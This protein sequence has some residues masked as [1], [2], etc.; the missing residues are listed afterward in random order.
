MKTWRELEVEQPY[1]VQ[2]LTNSVKRNRVSHAYL[3]QGMRGTGKLALAKTLTKTI[4]CEYLVEAEPCQECH[5]CIRIE[6]GNHPDVHFIKPDGQSIKIEQIRHL[7]K[8]FTYSGVESNKKA[9]VIEGAETLTVNAANRILKFLEEPSKQ[10]TALL[11]TENGQAMIPTIRSRCQIIDLQP[12]QTNTLEKQLIEHEVP[13][14]FARLL[15]TLT[16][17]LTEA[18]ELYEDAVFADTRN[19]V[20]QWMKVVFEQK[21]D[22]YLFVHQRWLSEL[23]E[24]SSLEL[25]LDLLLIAYKDLL[26]YLL[27][28]L[29]R[30][31]LFDRTDEKVLQYALQY[32]KADLLRYL[33][34]I[35]YAKRELKQN[36]QPT[37][38]MEKLALQV[39]K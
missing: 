35:L 12:V 17:N 1:A 29:D 25:G 28:D 14:E 33:N 13:A 22:L 3:L 4:F 32:Q 9:Y 31:V 23:K 2:V 19:L 37:L 6:S 18:L 34:V 21:D 7:Q 26:Y 8:E 36:V 27:G 30:I 38:V 16:N 5:T 39:K 24:R 20:V 11:L 10:T 15:V